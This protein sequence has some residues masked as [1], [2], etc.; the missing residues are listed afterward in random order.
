MLAA[1]AFSCGGDGNNDREATTEESETDGNV[2]EY[3]GSNITP[4][5]ED[6][7]DRLQVDTI[8]SAGSANEA[9]ESD[10]DTN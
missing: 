7:A 8:S 1:A 9:K 5:V 2:E 3:S 6:S 10:L 4:Q